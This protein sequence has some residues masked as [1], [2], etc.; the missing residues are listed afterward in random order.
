MLTWSS[1]NKLAFNAAKTKAMLF[2]T[3][4]MEKMH[5]LKQDVV[6]LKCKYKTL[7]NVDG[8]KLLGITK[9]KNLS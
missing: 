4:Q 2:T 3:S 7:E 8:F 5:G 6:K 1:S 9:D